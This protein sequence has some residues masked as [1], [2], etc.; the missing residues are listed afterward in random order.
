MDGTSEVSVA[1]GASVVAVIGTEGLLPSS[2]GRSIP[3]KTSSSAK[4]R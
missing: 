4:E 2:L 1:P 3:Q